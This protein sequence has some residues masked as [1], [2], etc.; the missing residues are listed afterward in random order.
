MTYKFSFYS[1]PDTHRIQ[2]NFVTDNGK[3]FALNYYIGI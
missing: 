1:I 3:E 2:L